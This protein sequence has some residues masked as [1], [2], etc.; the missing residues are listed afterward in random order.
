MRILGLCTF[1]VQNLNLSSGAQGVTVSVFHQLSRFHDVIIRDTRI[2]GLKRRLAILRSM[3]VAGKNWREF[4]TKTVRSYDQRS[5]IAYEQVLELRE[6]VDL[7][8]Q[9]QGMFSSFIREPLKP[10]VIFTDYTVALGLR[11]NWYKTFF[12]KHPSEGKKWLEREVSNYR[13]AARIFTYSE[14]VR[15]SMIQDYL[16]D[17]ERVVAT[18]VGV[19]VDLASKDQIKSLEDK[20]IIFIGHEPSFE[21]K[22]VPNLLQAF[23]L[24]RRK[25]PEAE[26]ILVG[27]ERTI[28]LPGVQ[29]MGRISERK[30]VS[31]LLENSSVFVMP[32]RLEPFGLVFIEA[33]AKK[34][35]CVGSKVD[36]IADIVVDGETGRL[37]PPEDPEALAAVLVELLSDESK[38]RLMGENG[39]RRVQEKYTWE[40]VIG[41]MEE[42]LQQIPL[43]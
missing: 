25:I 8:F 39:Y 42:H 12:V 38:L 36:G 20:R 43:S 30:R 28:E 27:V 2:R 32:S 16:V 21:R 26:L 35:A 4:L 18:G 23:S 6:S 34:V 40:V 9:I 41:K 10:Y 14:V 24:V 29:V 5:R 37:V 17:P 13:N 3:A 11:N 33:M 1:D 19:G 15:Q 22:G 31:E 7:I